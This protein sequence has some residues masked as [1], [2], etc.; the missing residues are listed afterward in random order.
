MP[1][2]LHFHLT[3]I[4]KGTGIDQQARAIQ[5]TLFIRALDLMLQLVTDI[6]VILQRALATP[7]DD[8]HMLQ[9]GRMCLLDA[10][11]DQRLIDN[12]QH[13]FGHRLGGR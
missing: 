13:L 8:R 6:E 11:L 12:R 9:T 1:E 3:G 4:G 10:I 2:A 5:I 7:G